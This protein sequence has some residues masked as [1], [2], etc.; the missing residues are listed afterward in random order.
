MREGRRDNEHTQEMRNI[1][2]HIFHKLY[3]LFYLSSDFASRYFMNCLSSSSVISGGAPRVWIPSLHQPIRITGHCIILLQPDR[4]WNEH[5]E[6]V[7]VIEV[8]ELIFIRSKQLSIM[9][10]NRPRKIFEIEVSLIFTE[11]RQLF[12]VEEW[13]IYCRAKFFEYANMLSTAWFC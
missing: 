11:R 9:K 7:N 12:C 2:I 8:V 3:G 1:S 5:T 13:T 4:V 6:H 10:L